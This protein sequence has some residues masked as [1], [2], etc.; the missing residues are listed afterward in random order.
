MPKDGNWKPYNVDYLERNI[1][2]VFR[3]GDIGK[4]TKGTYNSLPCTWAS[5][6]TM[7]F[8]VS[9]APMLTLSCFWRCYKGVSIPMTQTITSTG[10]TVKKPIGTSSNGMVIPTA[11]ALLKA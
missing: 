6:L 4:L 8:M 11:T 1:R 3:T 9:S 10:L 5:S 7:T 2:E